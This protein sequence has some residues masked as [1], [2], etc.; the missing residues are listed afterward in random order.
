MFPTVIVN[1]P[2]SRCYPWRFIGC[3]LVYLAVS[4]T[5]WSEPPL[6]HVD[7]GLAHGTEVSEGCSGAGNASGFRCDFGSRCSPSGIFHKTRLVFLTEVRFE[8]WFLTVF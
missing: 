3:G 5:A 8:V 6:S 4:S 7:E 1:K 2:L